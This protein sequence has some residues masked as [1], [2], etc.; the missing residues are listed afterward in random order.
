MS[1]STLSQNSITN[2]LEAS[3]VSPLHHSGSSTMKF[4]PRTVLVNWSESNRFKDD[5]EMDFETFEGI[6]LQAALDNPEGGY[7]KTNITVNFDNGHA[8]TCRIDLGCGGNEIGFTDH[9]VQVLDYAESLKVTDPNHWYLNNPDH[10]ELVTLV[11][12]YQLDR[13]LVILGRT[14][15]LEK[16][17]EIQAQKV[18]EKQTALELRRNELA[19]HERRQK[20]FQEGLVIPDNAK[21]VIVATFTEYDEERSDPYSDY[22]ASITTKTVVLAWSTHTRRLFPELRKACLNHPDT[23]FLNN[24]EL[25]SEHRENYSMGNGTYLT[26]LEYIRNGW[27][28]RKV[29]FYDESQKEKYVPM[30]Q[31]GIGIV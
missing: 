10:I 14:M 11:K 21:A 27:E 30:G 19:E 13:Q 17:K 24:K 6:A 3:N 4:S 2:P 1:H 20:A 7:D 23:E 12:T 25:S 29:V 16:V 28:V 31:V 5:G 15:V 9:C 8:H 18:A 26:D 22:Y